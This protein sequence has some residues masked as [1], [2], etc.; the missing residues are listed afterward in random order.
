LI[1]SEHLGEEVVVAG[2]TKTIDVTGHASFFTLPNFKM[3]QFFN[4]ITDH[5]RK[6]ATYTAIDLKG[7]TKEQIAAITGL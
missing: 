1:E 2:T 5:V 4:A 7:A 3:S 6:S